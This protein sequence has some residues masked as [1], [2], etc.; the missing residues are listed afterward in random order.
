[1]SAPMPWQ[2]CI[3][4]PLAWSGKVALSSALVGQRHGPGGQG[5]MSRAGRQV[6][7]KFSSLCHLNNVV[8]RGYMG[9]F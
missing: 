2:S 1:M 3:L 7:S 5:Q 9:Q 4:F 6:E 8:N